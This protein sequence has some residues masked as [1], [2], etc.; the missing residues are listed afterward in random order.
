[1]AVER[2]AQKAEHRRPALPS[3]I[4]AIGCKF[5]AMG[6]MGSMGPIG[7]VW[8]VYTSR[9]HLTRYTVTTSVNTGDFVHL[10]RYISRYKPLPDPLGGG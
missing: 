10:T 8:E 6:L 7:V 4:G 9:G 2:R 1:M 5:R 3:G